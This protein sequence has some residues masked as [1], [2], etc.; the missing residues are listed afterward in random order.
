MIRLIA[1][2]DSSH[3]KQNAGAIRVKDL[4]ED[5]CKKELAGSRTNRHVLVLACQ[6]EWLGSIELDRSIDPGHVRAHVM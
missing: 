3:D 2:E 5:H 4:V 6:C 1:D